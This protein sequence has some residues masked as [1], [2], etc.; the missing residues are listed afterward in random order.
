MLEKWQRSFTPLSAFR[1]TRPS[2]TVGLLIYRKCGL[3]VER[4]GDL[5]SRRPVA[6]V[7]HRCST[8]E[9]K[10]VY[11]ERTRRKDRCMT[12]F[13]AI[14]FV[15]M[16]LGFAVCSWLCVFRAIALIHAVVFLHLR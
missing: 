8:D 16:I 12:T 3:S 6:S 2:S 9:T 15:I 5:G 10:Q 11:P 4:L 7:K 14:W 13:K 1:E